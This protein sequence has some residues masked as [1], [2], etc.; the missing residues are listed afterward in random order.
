MLRDKD[1]NLVLVKQLCLL[2]L[3]LQPESSLTQTS[4]GHAVASNLV[5]H[6][7]QGAACPE[8]SLVLIE[9][10]HGP[11]YQMNLETFIK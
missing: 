7:F 2:P 4:F 9:T 6:C 11:C 3:I 5:A 10:K 8:Y 1:C